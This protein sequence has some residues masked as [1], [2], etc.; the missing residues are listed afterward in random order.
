MV[1]T[2]LKHRNGVVVRMAPELFVTPVAYV[3]QIFL[4]KGA[5]L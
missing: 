5:S 2:V 4:D 1:A 3:M